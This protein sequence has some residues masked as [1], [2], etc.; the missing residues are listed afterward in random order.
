VLQLFKL[1]RKKL[2]SDVMPQFELPRKGDI[3]HSLAD[4]SKA[5]GL[6]NYDPEFDLE[7]GLEIMLKGN[8]FD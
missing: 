6:L 7:R 8:E 5:E 4:I 3:S 2:G 1:L